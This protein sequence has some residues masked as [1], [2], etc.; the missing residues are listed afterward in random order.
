[1][2][3]SITAAQRHIRVCI[4]TNNQPLLSD[5]RPLVLFAVMFP[6]I[7]RQQLSLVL[8]GSTQ[9]VV[10]CIR[11]LRLTVEWALGGSTYNAQLW[12]CQVMHVKS[13]QFIGGLR[14]ILTSNLQLS[15]EQLAASSVCRVQVMDDALHAR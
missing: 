8:V 15:L 1:M 7:I 10:A 3:S 5:A 4:N 13:W 11:R 14:L 12:G 2:R 6:P 9:V